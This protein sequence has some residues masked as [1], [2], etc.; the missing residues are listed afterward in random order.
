[1]HC[2][3][4]ILSEKEEKVSI[5]NQPHLTQILVVDSVWHL[6]GLTVI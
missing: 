6:W 4:D 1:M 3:G 2:V 5:Y